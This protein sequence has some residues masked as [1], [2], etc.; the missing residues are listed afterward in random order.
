MVF[1]IR[2][3]SDLSR[4]DPE[5]KVIKAKDFWAFKDAERA[6]ADARSR[7]QQILTSAQH[8][9]QAE[10][11]RGYAEGTET[12][13][14]EQSGNMVEIVSQTV[15]Y[16]GKVE[17]QMVDLVL[18]AVRKVVSDFDDRQRV[19]TVVRNCLDLVRSQ[20]H[21]ALHVHPSQV[22]YMRGQVA[23]L[24]KVYPSITHIDVHPDARLGV[25]ACVVESE[26]GVVEAS[27]AGQVEALRD[28]LAVVFTQAAPTSEPGLADESPVPDFGDDADG[29]FQ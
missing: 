14:R 20:K 29:G 19:S 12:A 23:S 25:D 5:G 10:R 6:L 11:E 17:T 24:Q 9:Y 15:E 8:A 18:D 27:L 2:D 3:A 16:Y 4:P 22:D 21:L 7:H 26:I 28:A 13:K 1:L